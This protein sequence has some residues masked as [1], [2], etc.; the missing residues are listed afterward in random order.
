MRFISTSQPGGMCCPSLTTM[1]SEVGL[2]T[3]LEVAV[4]DVGDGEEVDN[5]GCDTG[6]GVVGMVGG[7]GAVG[8]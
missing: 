4:A 3:G 8:D 2:N 1:Y 6:G 5:G 7:D